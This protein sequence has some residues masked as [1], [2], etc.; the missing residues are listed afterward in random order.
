MSSNILLL[1]AHP[2]IEGS[3]ACAAMLEAV[4]GLKNVKVVDIYKTPL[5]VEN[6]IDDVKNA[7][8]LV[9]QF[10]FWWGSAPGCLKDWLDTY[11]CLDSWKIP[12]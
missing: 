3:K 5:E 6:Y 4:K 9:F 2:N 11:S 1:S 7:D 12:V 8:V 10:P